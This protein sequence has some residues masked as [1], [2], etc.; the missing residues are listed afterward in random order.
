MTGIVEDLANFRTDNRR[1]V[2]VKYDDFGRYLPTALYHRGLCV[3]DGANLGR[4]CAIAVI[5]LTSKLE[6]DHFF[7]HILDTRNRVFL[8]EDGALDREVHVIS[9]LLS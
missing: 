6:R 3:P 9:I 2:S 5:L 7:L 1:L 8:I 4:G